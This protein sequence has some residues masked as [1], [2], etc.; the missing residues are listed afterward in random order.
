MLRW[1]VGHTVRSGRRFDVDGQEGAFFEQAPELLAFQRWQEI[2]FFAKSWRQQLSELDLT[3]AYPIVQG[4]NGGRTRL[5]NLDEARKPPM[6]RD[7]IDDEAM[8]THSRQ[9][10]L[11]FERAAPRQDGR[12]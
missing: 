2:D 4:L 6:P 10:S 12:G 7:D 8:T 5:S 1:G 3:V 11:N 9:L